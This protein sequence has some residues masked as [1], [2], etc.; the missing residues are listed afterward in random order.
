[1]V[2]YKAHIF[3]V[4]AHAEGN[5]RDDDL[6]LITHPLALDIVSLSHWQVGVIEVARDLVRRRELFGQLLTILTGDAVDD[7]REVL[8]PRLQ[9]LRQVFI[10]VLDI[11]LRPDLVMQVGAIKT[12]LEAD[13][14]LREP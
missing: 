11:L 7:A 8:E 1:M 14:F 4:D 12:R 3:L 2:N 10:D 13:Q 6:N 9:Q 5:S